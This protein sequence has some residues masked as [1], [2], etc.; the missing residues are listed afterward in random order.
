MDL[1]IFNDPKGKTSTSRVV[2]AFVVVLFM[3]TWSVIS[4]DAKAM[5]M[6]DPEWIGILAV[7]AGQKATQS[8]A[9]NKK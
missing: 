9:E 7:L 6:I 4:I 8:F 1:Q 3:T 5:V 2:Y